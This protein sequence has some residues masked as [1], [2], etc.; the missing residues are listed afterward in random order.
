M[1]P[2][3]PF[4]MAL[5]WWMTL[6]YSSELL[7]LCPT[8]VSLSLPLC[9]WCTWK[10]ISSHW[11]R[12]LA[13]KQIDFVSWE[14]PVN[15]PRLGWTALWWL[16]WSWRSGTWRQAGPSIFAP[17]LGSPSSFAGPCPPRRSRPRR[18]RTSRAWA[19]TPH[20]L[21]PQRSQLPESPLT[22]CASHTK[23]RNETFQKV[24]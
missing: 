15:L 1:Y 24:I 22:F 4:I 13:I 5:V 17:P 14:S 2:W 23:T 10:I 16:T 18:Q 12:F 3:V 11:K 20:S 6:H 21:L 9:L 19:Q 7:S 8:Y